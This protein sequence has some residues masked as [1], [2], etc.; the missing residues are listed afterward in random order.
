MAAFTGWGG[1]APAFAQNPT[2]AWLDIADRL[3]DAAPADA[4]RAA[5]DQVDTSFFTPPVVTAAVFE[6][7]AAAGFTGGTILEPGCGAGAF[8]SAAPSEWTIAWTGVEVDPTSARIAGLLHP[9]AEIITGKLESTILRDNHFDAVVGNVPFSSVVVRDSEGRSGALHNYFIRRAIDA[10][11]PGGY[12]ILV[13]SRHTIDAEG[14]LLARIAEYPGAALIGAVRLPSGA[15]E[16]AG[17]EAVTDILAIRK[18]DASC[19]LPAL[20]CPPDIERVR[21]GYDWQLRPEYRITDH[22]STIT[23]PDRPGADVPRPAVVSRYWAQNPEHVAGQMRSTTYERSPLVV[24]SENPDLDISRAVTALAGVL[25]PMGQADTA[26]LTGVILEDAEGRKE[27]SFHLLDG[28]VHRVEGGRLMKGRQSKEVV[29]LIGLRD[30]AVDLLASES[31]PHTPDDEITPLREATA[32]AYEA[33]VKSFGNLNRGTLVEGRVD[34]ETGLP[35]LSWRRPAMGGFR[36]DPDAPLVMA[37]EVFDQESGVA[38]PA[39]I[40]TRR[41]NRIPE[42][43]QRV[44]SP[45][46]AVAVSLGE[47]GAIDLGRIAGLLGLAN[48]D[49]A[50]SA[51]GDLVFRTPAGRVVPAGE[52]LSGNVRDKLD[53]ARAAGLARNV[54]ALESVIPKDLG[55]F[56]ISITLGSPLLTPSDICAFL[57]EVLGVRWPSVHHEPGQGVWEVADATSAPAEALQYGTPDATPAYLVECALNARVPEVKDRIYDHNRRDWVSVR[58]VEKSAAANEKLELIRDRFSTWV[59]ED[60]ERSDRICTD[61]NR[62]LNAHVT[63]AYDGSGLTFPGLSADVTPWAHQRAAVE[64]VTSTPRALLAHPVGAGKTLEMALAARTLRQFGLAQKPL[65]VVP[66]HLLD[67]IAREAQQAFPTG[68]F[69]V[70]TKEDLAKDARRT[71]AA[72]CATGDWDAVIM[73][74]TSFTS[75]PVHPD[76]ETRWLDEQKFRLR[77]QLSTSEG[78]RKDKGPKAIARA[79][80]AL[81]ARIGKLRDGVADDG[82]IWFEQLGVDHIMIDEAHLFRRL[83]NDSSS[84]DNGLGSGSSKRATDLLVKIETL[85]ARRPEGAPIAAFFTGTPWSNTLA[86]TWVWQRYLQPET[87]EN[88]DLL[89]FDAWV[90]A[91]IRYETNIEVAPDGSG[92]RMQRRPVGIVNAPELKTMLAQVADILDPR[93]LGLAVPTHST[94]TVVVDPT[95][96]QKTYVAGLA[97]RAEA[98]RNK[99]AVLRETKDGR[100]TDDNMLLVSGDGRKAALDPHLVGI[101][102]ASSKLAKA[103]ELI[104]DAYFSQRDRRFGTHPA[105]GAFQLAFLDLGTPKPGESSTYGRLRRMLVDR[106]I[107]SGSVRFVHEATTD[108]ARAALF[109]ACRD[110]EVSVLIG[111]TSK[112]GMGTNVQTRLTHMWHIDAPWLPAEV[113]QRDGRGVRPGNLSEHVTITRL[114]TEGTFDAYTW[115]ALERKSRSFDALYSTGATAREI[116]DVSQATMSYGQIKALASGNP[117]LLDQAKLR[118]D[119]RKLELMRAVHLQGVRAQTARAKDLVA[120][121]D[122]LERSARDLQEAAEIATSEATEQDRQNLAAAVQSWTGKRDGYVNAYSLPA[123]SWRGLRVRMLTEG[124]GST[125][126]AGV[127]IERGY[128]AVHVI[129]LER[130]ITRR[131]ASVITGLLEGMLDKAIDSLASIASDNTRTADRYRG[132]AE[133]LTAASQA[134][135]W[136]DE[137]LLT[138]AI[139]RLAHIDS[140]IAEEA[141]PSAAAA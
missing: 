122:E 7:L 66:N 19:H 124:R 105:P 53:E 6:L 89:A 17:T 75:I 104:A 130:K 127:E 85:A 135:V 49:A 120:S 15:F 50:F 138:D 136:P 110:G 128:H 33:Y 99:T 97:E 68:K 118:A 141:A 80:R 14:G 30:L 132:Q 109:S 2:G 25:P 74:H 102:E 32:A 44:D 45:A 87:L 4:L 58:N 91:F 55:P 107:P 11:R 119:V 69:L 24:R 137:H 93:A 39:P 67:Q 21:V 1:L 9:N 112:V 8:M 63:R 126:F 115:Q 121:A 92:F 129:R 139:A 114:V 81:E 98:I 28:A 61:Y 46:E 12:V 70:A 131:P 57:T 103:A 78:G 133:Q 94:A 76:N 106:G 96:S 43:I 71:F 125:S 88:I 34:E 52:Y 51:L 42:P 77:M 41:V 59:W 37:L 113:I 64:R 72:R 73:T 54:A 140:L 95:P 111:S 134:G 27:G 86:E 100:R 13:T 117:L 31:N 83:G 20:P 10:V 23:T 26:E 18:N 56:D 38:G 47:S 82:A 108:K 36:K 79:I 116:E 62:K 40:L 60:Q 29:A 84:R 90:S 101:S 3:D 22:R 123:A 5:A 48:E 16:G 65:I 35:A